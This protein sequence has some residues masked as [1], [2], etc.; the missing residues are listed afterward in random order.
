MMSSTSLLP[1]MRTVWQAMKIQLFDLS[2]G[3]TF[4]TY[5]ESFEF[6]YFKIQ[7]KYHRRIRNR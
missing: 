2:T 7:R 4:V 3:E 1:M 6:I 5:V